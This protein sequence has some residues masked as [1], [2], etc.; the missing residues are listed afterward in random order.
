MR[1]LEVTVDGSCHRKRMGVGFVVRDVDT[2]EVLRES[3]QKMG[4][5]TSCQA[6]WLALRYAAEY[7]RARAQTLGDSRV[8]F[9]TDSQL[10]FRQ[11]S[12]EY[13]IRDKKLRSI[14]KPVIELLTLL[15]AKVRWHRRDEGDG[16]WADKLAKLGGRRG[17]NNRMSVDQGRHRGDVD[18][19]DGERGVGTPSSAKE[20]GHG[21]GQDVRVAE[22][23]QGQSPSASSYFEQA[24]PDA[25]KNGDGVVDVGCVSAP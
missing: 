4:W 24:G 14:S 13:K 2:Q 1:N 20:E 22:R 21:P 11:L 17:S 5:G 7:M 18:A 23:R 9:Y 3:S 25:Q 19:D 6:E 12:G 15:R 8:V 10:V 16:P